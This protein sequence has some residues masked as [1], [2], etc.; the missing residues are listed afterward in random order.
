[1]SESSPTSESSN[2]INTEETIVETHN[3]IMDLFT[4]LG[5][6]AQ[7]QTHIR[8]IKKESPKE[9][10]PIVICP[11]ENCDKTLFTTMGMK[12]HIKRHHPEL[13]K[14]CPKCKRPY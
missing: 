10:R 6:P 14:Q 3:K 8:F 7:Q 13:E 4:K 1:M 11:A 9:T 12:Y 2:T 5:D